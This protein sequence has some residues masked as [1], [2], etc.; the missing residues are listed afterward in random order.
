MA[1]AR[2]K[3][4]KRMAAHAKAAAKGKTAKRKAV[5]AARKPMKAKAGK[6]AAARRESAE[7]ETFEL[8][9]SRQ[10]IRPMGSE[11]AAV[12]SRNA[13]PLDVRSPVSEGKKAKSAGMP[14]LA[15]SALAAAVIA[16][17]SFFF[18]FYLMKYELLY[19]LAV[20]L[21]VFVAFTIAV[22]GMLEERGF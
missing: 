1:K 8:P 16:A 5:A 6:R 3:P 21:P 15:E 4:A 19:A 20:S 10:E 22:Q 11:A 2:K 13:K 9:V 7:L 17:V 12:Q 14:H 18:F